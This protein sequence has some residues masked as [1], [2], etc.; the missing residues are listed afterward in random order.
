VWVSPLSWTAARTY[1]GRLAGK[2]RVSAGVW[3][4]LNQGESNQIDLNEEWPREGRNGREK[5]SIDGLR[6]L[7]GSRNGKR[8][9]EGGEFGR[10][11]KLNQSDQSKVGGIWV[12]EFSH[13]EPRELSAAE[14]QPK[15][16]VEGRGNVAWNW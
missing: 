6:T 9:K 5:A 14:P 12:T 13:R 10:R 7:S 2:S 16:G 8:H 15:V 1:P 4:K 3:I 11:I